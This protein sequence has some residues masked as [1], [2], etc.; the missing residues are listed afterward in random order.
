MNETPVFKVY[1]DVD[2]KGISAV[3]TVSYG[4]ITMRIPDE[5]VES[6]KIIVRK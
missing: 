6:R 5:K 4:S 2:G 3:V 1:L